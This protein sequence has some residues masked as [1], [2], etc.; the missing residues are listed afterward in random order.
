MALRLVL[1]ARA[2]F[3]ATSL[4]ASSIAAFNPQSGFLDGVSSSFQQS[5]AEPLIAGVGHGASKS[6]PVWP[7]HGFAAGF[8]KKAG[9]FGCMGAV[10]METRTCMM[11]GCNRLP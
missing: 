1:H 4:Q 8:A 5:A 6:Q 3:A 11:N 7:G 10:R 2:G 9:G